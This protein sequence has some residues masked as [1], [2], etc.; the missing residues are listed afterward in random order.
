MWIITTTSKIEVYTLMIQGVLA[1][2]T[3]SIHD[4]IKWNWYLV[5][6]AKFWLQEIDNL[7]CFDVCGTSVI[8]VVETTSIHSLP[9]TTIN[10][11]K[12]Q[13]VQWTIDFNYSDYKNQ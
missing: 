10:A 7:A 9:T 13:A 11:A 6:A 3:K 12:G 1:H 2:T 5:S 4:S 8:W